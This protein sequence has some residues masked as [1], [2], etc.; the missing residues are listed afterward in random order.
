MPS[1]NR[2]VQQGAL[3]LN[4]RHELLKSLPG[5]HIHIPNLHG[6]FHAWPEATNPQIGALRIEVDQT[7]NK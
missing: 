4:E 7:L 5:Q 1:Y 3:G 6:L 2:S